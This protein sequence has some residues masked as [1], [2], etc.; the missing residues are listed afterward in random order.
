M[1][2][3]AEM[4]LRRACLR[5]VCAGSAA[6]RQGAALRCRAFRVAAPRTWQASPTHSSQRTDISDDPASSSLVRMPAV[7]SCAQ[8]HGERRQEQ[9]AAAC[10]AQQ[11]VVRSTSTSRRVSMLGRTTRRTSACALP[12]TRASASHP[13]RRGRCAAAAASPSTRPVHC[14]DSGSAPANSAPARRR[15]TH[16]TRGGCLGNAGRVPDADGAAE[17]AD[18]TAAMR[19]H[20]AA[21]PARASA[22]APAA[23]GMPDAAGKGTPP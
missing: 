21:R 5:R 23:G 14:R 15:A 7:S 1:D 2:P 19:V 6:P 8:S 17:Y 11:R 18:H 9:D 20:V 4:I 16:A 10:Q 22:A 3:P 13:P 12:G